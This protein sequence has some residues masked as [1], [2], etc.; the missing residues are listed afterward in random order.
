VR[1]RV[2]RGI[3][4]LSCLLSRHP[5]GFPCLH[6]AS[7]GEALLP[8]SE[9]ASRLATMLAR[10]LAAE[11]RRKSTKYQVSFRELTTERT[12]RLRTAV[13]TDG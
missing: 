11:S 3:R 1:G 7:S 9:R 4:A 6:D 10:I 5:T 8:W 13:N 12:I 2:D